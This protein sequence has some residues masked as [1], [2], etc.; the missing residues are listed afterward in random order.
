LNDL[1]I[2]RH[3]CKPE[4]DLKKSFY[5]QLTASTDSSNRY[6]RGLCLAD[7]VIAVVSAAASAC[8]SA[9]PLSAVFAAAAP[10]ASA[11]SSAI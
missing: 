8:L 6:L 4:F 11:A 5:P 3:V 9:A 7:A 2:Q 10:T 1:R